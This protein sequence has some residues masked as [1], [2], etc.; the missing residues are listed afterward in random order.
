MVKK[1]SYGAGGGNCGFR[2]VDWGGEDFG[3]KLLGCR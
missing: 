3:M 1:L 2:I